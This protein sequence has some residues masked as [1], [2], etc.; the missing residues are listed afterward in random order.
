MSDRKILQI[1]AAQ[2]WV[3]QFADDEEE[4][5]SPLVGW[6]LVQSGDGTA[7]VGLVAGDKEVELCDSDPGFGGY[8]FVPDMLAD[9]LDD[10]DDDLDDDFDDDEEEGDEPPPAP[11]RP[12]RLN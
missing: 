2:G 1:M 3:A 10:F 8:V 12:S 9:E 11:R 6:A 5:V 7:V 4:Y